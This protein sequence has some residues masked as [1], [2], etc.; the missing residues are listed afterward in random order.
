MKQ[1]FY[2]TITISYSYM[3]S[4]HQTVHSHCNHLS[5]NIWHAISFS[6]CIS[7]FTNKW[8]KIFKNGPS[9]ICGRQ[10]LKNL[11]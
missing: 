9:E 1:S 2:L 10:P 4:T 11:E 3:K 5:N 7:D 8:D 6:I